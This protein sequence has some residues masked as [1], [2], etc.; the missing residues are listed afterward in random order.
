M[1]SHLTIGIA[2]MHDKVSTTSRQVA[3]AEM[4]SNN[5]PTCSTNKDC[6]SHQSYG[7]YSYLSN[8]NLYKYII[9]GTICFVNIFDFVSYNRIDFLNK[10]DLIFVEN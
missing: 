10:L 2:Q 6:I 4:D 1:N 5:K 8:L 7:V 3:T 9:I